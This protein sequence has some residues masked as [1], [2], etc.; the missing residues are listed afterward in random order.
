MKASTYRPGTTLYCYRLPA[1]TLFIRPKGEPLCWSP[2]FCPSVK[3][4]I[5]RA[6]AAKGLR[7]ARAAGKPVNYCA[8]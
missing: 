4:P 6:A 8:V 1:G 3:V 2:S 7:E 5:T